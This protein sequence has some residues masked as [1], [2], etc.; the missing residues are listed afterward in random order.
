MQG[1]F[2]EGADWAS[3]LDP[4]ASEAAD[5]QK[6]SDDIEKELIRLARAR[7]GPGVR[8]PV[9]NQ[10]IRYVAGP[11]PPTTR[12]QVNGVDFYI[13]K[14]YPVRNV[15][16]RLGIFGHYLVTV[17]I[18]EV[19]GV[20][21]NRNVWLARPFFNPVQDPANPAIPD[22]AP[23]TIMPDMRF[24]PNSL[25]CV[26]GRDYTLPDGRYYEIGLATL[27]ACLEQA[28]ALDLAF[29]RRM[30]GLGN[31]ARE[32]CWDCLDADYDPSD[33][34]PVRDQ[35]LAKYLARFY[36]AV[37]PDEGPR[38]EDVTEEAVQKHKAF[39]QAWVRKHYRTLTPAVT[40]PA[41]AL[42]S[43]FYQ[44]IEAR[45]HPQ[46]KLTRAELARVLMRHPDTAAE[47]AS[48]LHYYSTSLEQ[49]RGGRNA[50]YKQMS[51]VSMA[52]AASH[53]RMGDLLGDKMIAL[54]A[55]FQ[56]LSDPH[57]R[58]F[59]AYVTDWHAILGQMP[60]VHKFFDNGALLRGLTQRVQRAANAAD[61]VPPWRFGM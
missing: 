58:C 36:T 15:R 25:Y 13:L 56:T 33:R 51:M 1:S 35:F 26:L 55:F 53:K 42:A 41:E 3:A 39:C 57:E 59:H 20:V 22:G 61:H 10:R 24:I 60:Q 17:V 45:F 18:D 8:V 5:R 43:D 40:A 27:K 29:A 2:P 28:E 54:S 47:F 30:E 6:R 38:V 31:V 16:A 52:R 32:T 4:G 34:Q 48:C 11:F 14:E 19:P 12:F 21:P 37:D 44:F 49:G 7:A 9:L 50:S 23:G 46:A